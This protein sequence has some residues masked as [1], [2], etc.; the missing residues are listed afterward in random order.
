MTGIQ[1]MGMKNY[2]ENTTVSELWKEQQDNAPLTRHFRSEIFGK[3]HRNGTTPV[4]LATFVP[5]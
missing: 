2:L 1:L 5:I 3:K 4:E